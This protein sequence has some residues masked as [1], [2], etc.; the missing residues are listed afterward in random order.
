MVYATEAEDGSIDLQDLEI[1]LKK[2]EKE[3]SRVKIGSFCAASNITGTIAEI[4]KITILLHRYGF[5]AF[6]DYATAAAYIKIDMNPFIKKEEYAL[7]PNIQS[8]ISKH[9]IC[10]K[11]K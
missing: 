5:L 7:I 10:E 9:K 3:E 2:Y 8:N 11:I 4:D 1:K 6:W